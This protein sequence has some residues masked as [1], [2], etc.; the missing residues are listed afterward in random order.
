MAY[1]RIQDLIQFVSR[2]QGLREGV[3]RRYAHLPTPRSPSL[4]PSDD[5]ERTYNQPNRQKPNE[6]DQIPDVAD[7]KSPI[8]KNEKVVEEKRT[9]YSVDDDRPSPPS[10]C[11]END[12]E[13]VENRKI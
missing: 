9:R 6:R 3:K 12:G 7:Y 4:F 2:G 10:H 11:A 5:H 13:H 1:N 8:W